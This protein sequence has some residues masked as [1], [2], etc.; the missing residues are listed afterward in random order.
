[1]MPPIV[2]DLTG[3]WRGNRDL[4]FSVTH[5]NMFALPDDAETGLLK[6]A[7]GLQMVDPRNPCHELNRNLHVAHVSAAKLFVQGC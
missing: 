1:M 5:D 2:N 3:L 6:G 7:H 4:A